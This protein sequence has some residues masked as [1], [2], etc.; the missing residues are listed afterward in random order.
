MN[1]AIRELLVGMEAGDQK[2]LDKAM[3]DADGTENKAKFGANAPGPS[4]FPTCR[5]MTTNTPC[6]YR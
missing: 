5:T 6:R 2:A 4:T 1:S 3:I